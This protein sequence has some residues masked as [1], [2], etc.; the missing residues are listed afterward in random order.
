VEAVI[1]R[2][3][4]YAV[5]HGAFQMAADE[6][7]LRSAEAGVA[8]L[9]FYGWSQTTASLGYFQS[10]AVLAADLLLKSLPFVRRLSGG[11]T[12]VHDHELTYCLT[13]PANIVAHSGEPW[14]PRMHRLIAESFA[15]FGL[16]GRLVVAAGP[17]VKHGDVLCFQQYTPGDLL[18]D[19]FKV[20]GSAQRK[21]HQHLMQHGGILLRRSEHAPVLP[22]VYDLTGIDLAP[23]QAIDSLLRRLRHDTGWDVIEGEWTQDERID[24]DVLIREKYGSP[25]WNEKR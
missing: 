2:L 21:H 4:P 14:M 12:L 16:A 9:R 13:L 22:G 19:G 3:L 8:T 15:D 11:A 1:C 6:V 10:H 5:E 18:C 20:V 24:I 7:L 23:R 25:S 17:T